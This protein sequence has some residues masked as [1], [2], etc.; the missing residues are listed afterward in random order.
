MIF[1]S[2]A[3][4]TTC[5]TT[6]VNN[7]GSEELVG[8][9]SAGQKQRPNATMLFHAAKIKYKKNKTHKYFEE[10]SA[11]RRDQLL[12]IIVQSAV[13]VKAKSVT[14]I[15]EVLTEVTQRVRK[16]T[17]ERLEESRKKWRTGCKKW[18]NPVAITKMRWDAAAL[19]PTAYGT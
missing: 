15:E 5:I 7:I 17:T 8:M 3:N 14:Y 6:R 16:R 1:A 2:P 18:Q 4:I 9:F 19:W 11:E 13:T 10:L 12:P